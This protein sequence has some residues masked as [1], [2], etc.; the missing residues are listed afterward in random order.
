VCLCALACVR[1]GSCAGSE[2]CAGN[3]QV[4]V[5]F[6]RIGCEPAHWHLDP[7]HNITIQVSTSHACL[8]ACAHLMSMRMRVC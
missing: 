4:G 6:S 2:Q 8:C 1:V 3:L 7:N 5:Y